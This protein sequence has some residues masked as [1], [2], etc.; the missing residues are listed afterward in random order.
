MSFLYFLIISNLYSQTERFNSLLEKHNKITSPVV[1]KKSNSIFFDRE[2]FRNPHPNTIRK[3]S[4]DNITVVDSIIIITSTGGK[5]RVTFGFD[6]NS[7]WTSEL[8]EKWD[9][10][11]WVNLTLD[12]YVFDDNGNMTFYY[13]EW[14]DGSQWVNNYQQETYTY[15]P[16]GNMTSHLIE[17][18]DSNRWVN[19]RQHIYTYNYDGNMTSHLIEEWE[20]NNWVNSWRETYVFDS[21]GNMSSY[22]SKR[23]DGTNW[24]NSWRFSFTYNLNGNRVTYL[25]EIGNSTQWVNRSQVTYTY[26]SNENMVSQ[27]TKTWNGSQWSLYERVTYTYDSD[28]NMT[29]K[30]PENWDGSKWVNSNSGST[31]TYDSNGNMI[32]A[33]YETVDR[34]H[35]GQDIFIWRYTYTYDSNGNKISHFSETLYNN[36]WQS[37]WLYTYTYD[38]N[39][40]MISGLFESWYGDKDGT[41]RFFDSFGNSYKYGGLEINVYYSTITDVAEEDLNV[42]AFTLSQNYPN[43]FNPSTIISYSIPKSSFVQLKIYDMLGREVASLV[44]EE[45]AVGN[46]KVGFNASNLTSGV[47]FYRLQSGEFTET[48]KLILL[49]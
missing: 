35:G 32:S 4:L 37:D 48:K 6:S 10:S 27:L 21:N 42:L 5:Y 19:S 36:T 26:N 12:T 15:D 34:S 2:T 3:R 31:Y 47:Y 14:W 8:L 44:D 11:Q 43:P 30:F 13:Y 38:D 28:G 40:D 7:N 1:F 24:V 39:G 33:T 46:Y 45:Q 22:F 17:T 9:G 16:D 25:S 49:R 18:W 29:S 20:S 23:W 41:F